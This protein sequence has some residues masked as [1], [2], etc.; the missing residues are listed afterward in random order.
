[1]ASPTGRSVADGCDAEEGLSAGGVAQ[2][3]FAAP[4]APP[5]PNRRAEAR[6]QEVSHG[7][8]VRRPRGL[9]RGDRKQRD[10]S[11]CAHEERTSSFVRDVQNK[12]RGVVPLR[13][14]VEELVGDR[15][16]PARVARLE[17]ARRR[18]WYGR[19]PRVEAGR[20]DI[21][22]ARAITDGDERKRGPRAFWSPCAAPAA[23]ERQL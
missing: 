11:P 17:A 19:R 4:I 9:V 23:R 7:R 8:S 21:F 5:D 20:R 1:M 10:C 22:G 16:I 3:C 18:R 14:D 2:F 6:T 15:R 12:C 13:L